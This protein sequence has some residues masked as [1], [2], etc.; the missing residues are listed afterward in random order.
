MQLALNQ[1]AHS[2]KK[3]SILFLIPIICFV[4]FLLTRSFTVEG[5]EFIIIDAMTVLGIIVSIL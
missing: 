4:A 2:L 3:K 1:L 5:I